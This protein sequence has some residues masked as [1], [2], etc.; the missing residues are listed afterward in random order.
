MST[1]QIAVG[2]FLPSVTATI[3]NG[4]QASSAIKCMG[5]VPVGI[6]LP[7]AFT[8]T[9]L[10]FQVCD[11]ESGTYQT[12]YG[13]DGN[14]VSM[15]VAQGRTYAINPTNFEGVQF[16]KVVSGSSEGGARTLILS[17]KGK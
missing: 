11:T 7:A 10:T 2:S 16:L 1:Q 15:T 8:G 6:I 14:A 12:L 4:Q 5:M 9:A 3:A 17:L 13:M